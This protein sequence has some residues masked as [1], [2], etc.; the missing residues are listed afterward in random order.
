MYHEIC[1]SALHIFSFRPNMW[2]AL[3]WS[4]IQISD[5][6]AFQESSIH[7]SFF[8]TYIDL[9]NQ[10]ISWLLV[11]PIFW[12]Y[13]DLFSRSCICNQSHTLFIWLHTVDNIYG[14][15]M[16][17]NAQSD[18]ELY[19]AIAEKWIH[20]FLSNKC[21]MRLQQPHQQTQSNIQVSRLVC[22]I[23]ASVAVI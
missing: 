16:H 2:E 11:Q 23:N 15:Q 6:S 18:A 4:G 1:D 14:T 5:A 20:A 21:P 7:Q 9:L 10:Q 12:H 22:E 17:T 19:A 8:F 13:S 3:G